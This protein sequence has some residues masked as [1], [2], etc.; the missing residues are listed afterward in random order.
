IYVSGLSEFRV[1]T[2]ADVIRMLALGTNNR[3]TRSTDFNLT[4]SRSHAILQLTFEIETQVDSGQTLMC[5]SKLY[6]VDVAGSQK[7]PYLAFDNPKHLKELTSINN[8]LSTLG[9]VISALASST[10][11]HIPYRD[12]KLTRI[13]QDSLG[14]NPRTI[15]IA[16][17]A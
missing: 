6:L 2:G 16:C 15:L 4:S 17:V 5:R 11:S 12:S 10:R 1:Q 7:I 3:M 9:N 13:L 14:G 8:S